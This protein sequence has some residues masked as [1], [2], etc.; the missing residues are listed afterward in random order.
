VRVPPTV[1]EM[2]CKFIALYPSERIVDQH[3]RRSLVELEDF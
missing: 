3:A 2:C 1:C